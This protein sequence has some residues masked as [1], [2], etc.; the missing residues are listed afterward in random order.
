MKSPILKSCLCFLLV[1]IIATNADAQRSRTRRGTTPANNG[2]ATD[3]A[4][5][6]QTN[7]TSII[8]MVIFLLK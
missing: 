3:P 2:Q 7:N 4:Q 8:L 1:A 6:E 5:Q